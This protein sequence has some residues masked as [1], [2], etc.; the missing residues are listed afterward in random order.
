MKKNEKGII[1]EKT[2]K[3]E[4]HILE[5]SQPEIIVTDMTNLINYHTNNLERIEPNTFRIKFESRDDFDYFTSRLDRLNRKM[6]GK[7]KLSNGIDT[8]RMKVLKLNKE[9]DILVKN[10]KGLNT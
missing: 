8:A 7:M 4:T 2:D 10:K 1:I 3:I 9:L 5:E 6:E